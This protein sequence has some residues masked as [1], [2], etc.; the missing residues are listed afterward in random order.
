MAPSN[1]QWDDAVRNY[2]LKILK[3]KKIAVI[4]DTTGYG[5]TAREATSVAGVQEGRR[6]SGLPG[7]IDATQPDMTPDMLRV[8]ECRRRG[9]RGVEC[10]HR[11][12]SAACSTPAPRMNW[13]VPFVGHPSMGSGEIGRLVDKPAN[14]KRSTPSAT[15]AAASM[16]TASCRR[17]TPG[18]RRPRQRQDRARRIR[19]SGGSPAAST[20][21]TCSPRRSKQTG[22]TAARGIIGY[23]NT[24]K[25]YPGLFRR[26]H[27]LADPAQRLSRPTRS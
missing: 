18:F 5:V 24:L 27:V 16:P 26:L 3:V 14:W 25:K 2:C 10:H 22:S 12:G 17:R 9:D 8:Q 11:H 20:P 1:S 6:R 23:W 7:H 21:S 19:C 13:D 4:G 15:R